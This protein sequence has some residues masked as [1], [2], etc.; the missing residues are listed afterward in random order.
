MEP[1]KK[2]QKVSSDEECRK[3]AIIPKSLSYLEKYP[4]KKSWYDLDFTLFDSKLARLQLRCNCRSGA[5]LPGCCSHGN[6][7]VWLIYFVLFSDYKEILKQTKRDKEIMKNFINLT[8]YS[9]Y[10][11]SKKARAKH[12]CYCQQEKNEGWVQCD[13]CT[14][15]YHPSCTGTTME[16]IEKDKYTFNIWH[17]KFCQSNDVW[18]VRNI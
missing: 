12:W 8:P 15:W 10:Q 16:D 4:R 17:C 11:K 3:N 18:V 14:K 6:S 1:P 5:Q 2:K 7:S 13:K 9:I